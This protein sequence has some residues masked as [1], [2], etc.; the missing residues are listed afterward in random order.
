MTRLAAI[1]LAGL[2]GLV[3]LAGGGALVMPA[4][5][6]AQ[7]TPAGLYRAQAGPDL[8]S[9]IELAPDGRFRYQLSEGALDEEAAGRWTATEDGVLL[10]TLPAP[11]PPE[12]RIDRIEQTG[13]VPLKVTVKVPGGD[14]LQGIFLRVGYTNGDRGA[15]ATQADGWAMPADDTRQ[16]AWIEFSEPIH[17][18]TSQRFDLPEAQRGLSLTVLLVPNEIGV[19]AFDGTRATITREGLVLHWRGRDI[20]YARAGRSRGGR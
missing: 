13:D 17:G 4:P 9:A 10:H 5:A 1:A 20:P 19:A 16:P 15:A 3:A 14:N 2:A 6:L 18:V 11:R 7:S 12:W 8:A